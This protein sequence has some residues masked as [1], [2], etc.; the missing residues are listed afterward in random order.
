MSRYPRYTPTVEKLHVLPFLAGRRWV[1]KIMADDQVLAM[2][3]GWTRGGAYRLLTAACERVTAMA[4]LAV[5]DG[6]REIMGRL[7]SMEDLL[8]EKS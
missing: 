5:L 8:K 4:T 7:G 2:G 1:W 6:H 3:H